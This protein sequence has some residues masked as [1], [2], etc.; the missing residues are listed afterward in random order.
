MNDNNFLPDDYEVPDAGGL[1]M[2]LEDGDNKF[3][4]VGSVV[5]GWIY[6]NTENKPVRLQEKP[7]MIPDDIG[8]K[9]GKQGTVKHFWA[10]PVYIPKLKKYQVLELTQTTLMGKLRA[11]HHNEDWGNPICR[12]QINIVKSG[13]GLKTEYEVL[14]IN[15]GAELTDNLEL[16]KK[17]YEESDIKMEEYFKSEI[18]PEEATAEDIKM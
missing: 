12:Y 6:W 15:L 9:D 17:G 14:P 8:S 3:M 7:K 1:F 11:M 4:I 18:A 16:I 5:L 10:I 2:K 13:S